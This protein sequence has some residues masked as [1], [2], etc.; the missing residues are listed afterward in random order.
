[1]FNKMDEKH[2]DS[3][4]EQINQIMRRKIFAIDIR[5]FIDV[6]DIF[7]NFSKYPTPWPKS[8]RV[9]SNII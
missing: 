7:F 9:M 8:V 3:I 1:M 2:F 6:I 4:D 5:L